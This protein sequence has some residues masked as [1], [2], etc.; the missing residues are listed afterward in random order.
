MSSP[1]K[2]FMFSVMVIVFCTG[3]GL[4]Q[5]GRGRQ[6][7]GAG[8]VKSV[9]DEV[10]AALDKGGDFFLYLNS[11]EF[12][13]QAEKRFALLAEVLEA[14]ARK[15]GPDKE[16]EI[17]ILLKLLDNFLNKSGIKE[18]AAFGASS[19]KTSSRGMY[20]AKLM[21]HHYEGEGKGRLWQM[22]AAKNHA[23][24]GLD[25][26]P[27][28]TA[29]AAFGDCDLSIIWDWL[30][31]MMVDLGDPKAKEE[32]ERGLA[33]AKAQGMDL[34]ALLKS[35]SGQFGMAIL[36]DEENMITIPTGEG[37]LEFPEPAVLHF[38]KVKDD[39]IMNAFKLIWMHARVP[40]STK[41]LPDGTELYSLPLPVPVP[42]PL[43]PTVALADGWL[44]MGSN[45]KVVTQALAVKAGEVKGLTATRGFRRLSRGLPEKGS[46]FFYLH[47]KVLRY[48]AAVVKIGLV[49]E[50]GPDMAE[51]IM[52]LLGLGQNPFYVCGIL[53]RRKNGVLLTA[54]SNVRMS[55]AVITSAVTIPIAIIAIAAEKRGKGRDAARQKQ[56]VSNL[57]QI[58]LSLL[59]YSFDHQGKFPAQDGAAGLNE[60][61]AGKFLTTPRAYL[62]PFDKQRL[63]RPMGKGQ[64]LTEANLSYVHFGGFRDDDPHAAVTPICFDKPDPGVPGLTVLFINGTVQYY[65]GKYEN[66]AAVIKT[67]NK[68]LKIPPARYKFL[69]E[70]AQNFD[71]GRFR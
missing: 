10:S 48:C 4:A 20:R 30:A 22:V 39:S 5:T 24:E 62:S 66:C 32:F 44:I 15:K 7:A 29:A 6:P 45:A 69:L 14:D 16:K 38:T 64:K 1:A 35:T 52:G 57:E 67:L 65:E 19:V 43:A 68:K 46:Q 2:L 21:W 3:N 47:P 49:K 28:T 41:K 12:V 53:E 37:V 11:E 51:T 34:E 33:Q 63:G 31:E 60:L 9:F 25:L 54:N 26:L 50:H 40:F 58:G 8:A 70:K 23:I 27:E 61:V 36:L 17:Q 42:F 55:D 13:R 59:N 56:N 71:A 18:I